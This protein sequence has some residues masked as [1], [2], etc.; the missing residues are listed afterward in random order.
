MTN[1]FNSKPVDGDYETFD[2]DVSDVK[3]GFTIPE[4]DYDVEL[5]HYEKKESK[6][7]NPMWLGTFTILSGDEE[8]TDLKDFCSL[9]PNALFSYKAM[10]KALGILV[11]GKVQM[12]PHA[13]GRK[14]RVSVKD[15]E[16]NG[17]TNSKIFNYEELPDG[18]TAKVKKAPTGLGAATS[19]KPKVTIPKEE[20]KPEPEVEP[21]T[22]EETYQEGDTYTNADGDTFVLVNGEW[23]PVDTSEDTEEDSTEETAPEETEEAAPEEEPVKETPKPTGKKPPKISLK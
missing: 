18:P 1:P 12:G 10:G 2:V 6:A 5:T 13:I 20:P 14:C 21:E 22:E 8:G 11:D 19:S 3:D 7:G 16:Y 4:G 15:E 9:Q 17:R 23:E